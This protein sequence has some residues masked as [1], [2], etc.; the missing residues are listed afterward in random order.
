MSSRSY[1][2]TRR[3]A[4]E[5]D[6]I[7]DAWSSPQPVPDILKEHFKRNAETDVEDDFD[8]PAKRDGKRNSEEDVEYDAPA[9]TTKNNG[10]VHVSKRSVG[11]DVSTSRQVSEINGR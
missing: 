7:E 5:F 11:G 9:A 4:A 8:T 3:R 10:D 2:F 1:F 6:N